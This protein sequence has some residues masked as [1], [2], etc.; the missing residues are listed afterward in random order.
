MLTNLVWISIVD[1]VSQ[2][3]SWERTGARFSLGKDNTPDQVQDF[4]QLL[5]AV[6]SRLKRLTMIAV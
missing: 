4:L 1:L 3:L 5:N 6:L 2:V